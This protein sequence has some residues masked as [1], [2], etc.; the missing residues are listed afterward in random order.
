MPAG[1]SLRGGRL[2][3]VLIRV[4]RQIRHLLGIDRAVGFTI[5]ARS[6]TILSGALTILLI[7]HFLSAVEQGYYY[8]FSSLVALQTV[9]ELGFSFVILQLAAHECSHL[10]ICPD[11]EISGNE[12]GAFPPGGRRFCKSLSA[13]I[14]LPRC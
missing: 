8:T 12:E 9:F 3:P 5:L 11:G 4:S 7:A 2:I 10:Q 6:W 14:Q 13:G 1:F